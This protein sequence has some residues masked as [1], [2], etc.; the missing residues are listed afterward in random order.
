MTT[1]YVQ[2]NSMYS[3]SAAT[4]E[5]FC[6]VPKV[7]RFKLRKKLAQAWGKKHR[8]EGLIGFAGDLRLA[9]PCLAWLEGRSATFEEGCNELHALI[10][11]SDGTY[12]FEGY[13][14]PFQVVTPMAI[15]SGSQAALALSR[16][17]KVKNALSLMKKVKAVDA[18]TRGPTQHHRL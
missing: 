11:I 7:F 13:W 14:P 5:S 9:Q 4:A 6:Y 1:I 8:V 16:S 17:G 2:G 18:Y 15:G 10:L 3:D 12:M